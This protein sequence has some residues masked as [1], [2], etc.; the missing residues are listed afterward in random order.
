MFKMFSYAYSLTKNE[1]TAQ[2]SGLY[3]NQLPCV[4]TVSLSSWNAYPKK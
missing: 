4:A 3:E 1:N 2:F